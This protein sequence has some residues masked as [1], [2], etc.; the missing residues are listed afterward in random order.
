MKN[1]T[2]REFGTGCCRYHRRRPRLSLHARGSPSRK[3]IPQAGSFRRAF[4]GAAP[5]PPTRSKAQPTKTA[6]APPSGTSSPTPPAI[7]ANGDTGDVADD[8]YHL[9]KE[10]IR[11][12]KNLGVA[13]YRMSISWSRIFPNGP[14]SPIPRD[15]TT[16]TASSTSCWPTKSRLTSPS[17]I[18]ICP[19]ALPGRLAVARHRK[20]LRRIRRLRHQTPRRPRPPLDDDQRVRLLHRPRLQ[21]RPLCPRPQ[22]AAGPGQPGAPQRHSGPRPRRPGHPRQHPQRNPGGPR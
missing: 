7:T 11:L 17:S 1:L 15:S 4:S 20:G 12:L 19:Q 9:Y 21:G 18:G 6:A 22:A 8:S 16:T 13:T 10:D 2:R 3:L 14:A 5:P